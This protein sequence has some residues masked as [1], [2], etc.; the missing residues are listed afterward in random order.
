MFRR[1]GDGVSSIELQTEPYYPAVR[2]SQPQSSETL[3]VSSA[4]ALIGKACQCG[5]SSDST[6]VLS[7]TLKHIWVGVFEIS[8]FFGRVI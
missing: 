3:R 8:L 6:R 2:G 4:F 7:F 5:Y 1:K